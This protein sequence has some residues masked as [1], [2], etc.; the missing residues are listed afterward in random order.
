MVIG[1]AP[2][3]MAVG[4]INKIQKDDERQNN[5]EGARAFNRW[6][7]DHKADGFEVPSALLSAP[8][9][10][11]RVLI[12]PDFGLIRGKKR[13]CVLLWNSKTPPL[14]R[15]MAGLGVFAMQKTLVPMGFEQCDF[16]VHD[17]R[18]EQRHLSGAI[19]NNAASILQIELM[20]QEEAFLAGHLAP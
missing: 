16:V 9:G 20:R 2:F 7:V 13:E 5:Q 8:K 17:L 12:R 6:W 14:P 3:D 10:E 11:L 19:P 4:H 1:G 18:A 15:R